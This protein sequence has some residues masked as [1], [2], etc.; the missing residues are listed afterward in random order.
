MAAKSGIFFRAVPD[1][2]KANVRVNAK[3]QITLGFPNCFIL[4]PRL[5]QLLNQAT[6]SLWFPVKEPEKLQMP[7]NGWI[8]NFCADP[9][10][11]A[12]AM[13]FLQKL[14]DDNKLPVFNHPQ[15]ILNSR[16]DKAAALLEGVDG[17][18]VPQC[19][20][21]SPKRPEDFQQV[22]ADNGFTYPVLVRPAA[23]QSG[24]ELL[25]IEDD[26]GW[27]A[28]HGIPWGGRTMH[29]TQFVDFANADGEYLK[30]RAVCVGEQVYI[31]HILIADDW[32]VHAMDRTNAIVDREFDLHRQLTANPTFQAVVKE[33]RKRI[34][35]DFFGID[36]GWRGDDDFVLFEANAAMSI[37]SR[38]HMP[39]YRRPEYLKILKDIEEGVI[40]AIRAVQFR[41]AKKG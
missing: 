41:A 4:T 16:R 38:A 10:E 31:R 18:T 1:S 6:H 35:L 17:L 28:I 29:M 26:S 5:E 7:R 40:R 32:L 34:G 27:D 13:D 8:V 23:S 15:G 36:L 21:F 19:V 25:R 2:G 22:F 39:E 24:T 3:N 12:R 9:D 14:A 30:V 33:A 11:Y 20:R 37:L